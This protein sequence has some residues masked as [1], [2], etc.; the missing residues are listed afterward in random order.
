M[1]K[2]G[3]R[4][5]RGRDQRLRAI[6]LPS[7]KIRRRSA[8]SSEIRRSRNQNTVFAYDSV[9]CDPVFTGRINDRVVIGIG[10]RE[11][12]WFF[13]LR[14]ALLWPGLRIRRSW[15]PTSMKI[16]WHNECT[17]ISFLFLNLHLAQS[18]GQAF[19]LASLSARSLVDLCTRLAKPRNLESRFNRT[20]VGGNRHLLQ[21]YSLQKCLIK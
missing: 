5:N 4:R 12:F 6:R 15:K 8:V 14:K 10:K 2:A 9:V 20:Y 1:P 18:P 21:L 3:C 17:C 7:T 11:T 13:R 19:S 16:S